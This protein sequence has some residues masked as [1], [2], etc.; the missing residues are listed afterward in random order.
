MTKKLVITNHNT[1]EV[2]HKV[3]RY[4]KSEST[5][6]PQVL[7]KLVKGHHLHFRAHH[8]NNKPFDW[9]VI[10]HGQKRLKIYSTKRVLSHYDNFHFHSNQRVMP[11]PT[12]EHG[13]LQVISNTSASL[14]HDLCCYVR[15]VGL[16][17][18]SMKTCIW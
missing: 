18:I 14:R 11:M 5:E 4:R 17:H 15:M 6:F 13:S 1:K 3:S 16:G 9:F 7:V 8:C 12:W 2:F 10:K